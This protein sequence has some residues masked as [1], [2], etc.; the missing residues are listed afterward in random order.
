[1]L[2]FVIEPTI[3]SMP[4]LNM[5]FFSNNLWHGIPVLGGPSVN[6]RS[7]LSGAPRDGIATA[8]KKLRSLT[9]VQKNLVSGALSFALNLMDVCQVSSSWFASARVDRFRIQS[10]QECHFHRKLSSHSF[11]KRNPDQHRLHLNSESSNPS[12][13][14]ESNGGKP[15]ALRRLYRI[16]T[17]DRERARKNPGNEAHSSFAKKPSS[18]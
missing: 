18:K 5:Q 6:Q 16:Q 15:K 8:L 2:P 9:V 12:H 13:W 4:S 10:Q 1:M 17:F 11:R 14:E 3:E 7:N